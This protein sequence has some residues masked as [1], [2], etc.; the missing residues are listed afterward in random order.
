[1]TTPIQ[2]TLVRLERWCDISSELR[3]KPLEALLLLDLFR[4]C[5]G[6]NQKNAKS[7]VDVRGDSHRPGIADIALM[8]NRK[9]RAQWVIVEIKAP[10]FTIKDNAI[11]Q[12]ARYAAS[13]KAVRAIVT[14]G[15]SWYFIRVRPKSETNRMTL[16]DVLFHLE[17]GRSRPKQRKILEMVLKRCSKTS[18][19]I[20]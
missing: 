18:S 8:V 20:F 16:A 13:N 15:T 7:Q 3:E 5:L 19:R 12:A 9:R 4:E 11:T 10:K 6:Y 1:M 14:N 17:T 2:E